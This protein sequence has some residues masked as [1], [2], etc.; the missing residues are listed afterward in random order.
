MGKLLIKIEYFRKRDGLGMVLIFECECGNKTGLFATGDR[1][2]TG[3]EFIELEDD[4][5]MTYV[6][7][8]DGVLF[9]CKFCGYTYRMDKL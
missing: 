3:R 5:R 8:E 6:V 4:D 1:D 7:G 9:K 2:E